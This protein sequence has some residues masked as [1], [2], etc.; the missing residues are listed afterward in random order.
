MTVADGVG[1]AADDLLATLV[2]DP[3]GQVSPS[4]YETARLVALAPWLSGHDERVTW[5]LDRQRPDGGW[6]PPDGYGL[7]P[8]LSATEALLADATGR[9]AGGRDADGAIPRGE[10]LRAAER[11]LRSLT[12]APV[13]AVPDT[14]A[15]DLI[16]PALA[17]AIDHRSRHRLGP[18]GGRSS[19]GPVRLPAGLTR[20]RLDALHRLRAAGQSLP[21]KLRHA[22]EVLGEGARRLTGIRPE[23]PGVVGASP[24]ATVAWLGQPR[25]ADETVVRYLDQVVHRHLHLAPCTV[26]ITVF[27]RAW[28]L[29]GL[30]RAGV[31]V[32]VPDVLPRGLVAA[33]GPSGAATG[34]GLPTDADTTAVVLYALAR[35]GRPV[36]PDSLWA[37]DLGRHFCTWPGEDGTSVSTNA[38]VLEAFGWHHRHGAKPGSR[39]RPVIERLTGWLTDQQLAEG[40][41]V[42]RWH[43]SPFYATS[44]AALALADFGETAAA[45]LA[46]RRAVDWVLA[47]ERP[48]GGWGHTGRTVE[49]TGYAMQILLTAMPTAGT[50]PAE[51]VRRGLASLARHD[52]GADEPHLWHD[53]DLYRPD[54]II[55]SSTLAAQHRARAWLTEADRAGAGRGG[56]SP[57]A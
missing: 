18:P 15:V 16:A 48:G 13:W 11:G 52:G 50:V 9:D 7:V 45:R 2:R 43:A 38:H 20:V 30:S 56:G 29:A 23:G 53:K 25:P 6:G 51:V 24:A 55:R 57:M 1:A 37:Y 35:L 28:V 31:P 22:L 14:P 39:Y 26:P 36:P 41:W 17:A 54:A 49:E 8:T 12:E 42:D 47:T 10:R 46:V 40:C 34:P 3:W 44:C 19:T 27:E 32:A 33:L 21:R 4:V 5:L